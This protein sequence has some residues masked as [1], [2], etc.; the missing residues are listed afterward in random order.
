M[1][2]FQFR[3]GREEPAAP[4]EPA[5]S[6]ETMRRRALHRLIG[7]ALL[8]LAAVIGLPLVFDNQPRPIALD[9]PIEIADKA[10][11][12]P[13]K[14]P[15][16]SAAAAVLVAADE[17]AS[18]PTVQAAPAEE[19]MPPEKPA[20][21]LPEAV[22]QGKGSAPKQQAMIEEIAPPSKAASSEV[23]FV[24]QVGA[25]A[26]AEKVREVRRSVESTGLRT[27]TQV[28]ETKEGSRTRV[29]VGPFADR[30]QAQA[31]AEKIRK[32]GLGATILTL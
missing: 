13:L 2:F 25:F 22:P 23:R 19:M 32:H 6:V 31:A 11:V 30:A 27:Y 29:R 8:V 14:A 20:A 21:V 4:P 26:E 7:A 16:A 9:L 28:V 12:A 10:K 15:P 3:K 24:V 5:Q 17:P 1:A 18:A